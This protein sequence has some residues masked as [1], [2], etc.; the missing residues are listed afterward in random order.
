[1][2]E[3]IKPIKFGAGAAFGSGK[4]WQSW[5]HIK[6]L[7]SLF[8][9]AVQHTLQGVYNGVAPNPVSNLELTKA[10]AY[11]LK[12]PLL[13]PNIPRFAMKLALG[14]MHILLFESQRVSSKKVEAE[15][16]DFKYVN[17][18]PALEDLLG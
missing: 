2:P 8:V 10:A 5:I 18:K 3:I 7:A 4:Q 14:E 11:V 17:L 15:N 6:D 16:F 9:F 12:R 1:M 13:L